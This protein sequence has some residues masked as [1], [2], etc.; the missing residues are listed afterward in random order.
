MNSFRGT[1]VKNFHTPHLASFQ[2]EVKG[3]RVQEECAWKGDLSLRVKFN[4]CMK[5][6]HSYLLDFSAFS[7]SRRVSVHKEQPGML[8]RQILFRLE[9]AHLMGIEE[10]VVSEKNARQLHWLD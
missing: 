10:T 2:L 3:G 9:S 6:F 1:L 4:C 5:I 7:S 8:S